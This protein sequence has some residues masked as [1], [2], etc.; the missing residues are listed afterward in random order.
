MQDCIVVV[1]G[2]AHHFV[3]VLNLVAVEVT[4]DRQ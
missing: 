1:P 4:R 2:N 3:A